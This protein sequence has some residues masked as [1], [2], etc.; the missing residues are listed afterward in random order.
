MLFDILDAVV[1][2]SFFPLQISVLCVHCLSI[3]IYKLTSRNILQG[4]LYVILN[5]R[6]YMREHRSFCN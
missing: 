6:S 3:F 4:N 1:C 2:I 5:R